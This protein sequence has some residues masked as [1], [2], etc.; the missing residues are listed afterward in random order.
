M[1]EFVI[2]S[3]LVSNNNKNRPG[4]NSAKKCSKLTVLFEQT[5]KLFHSPTDALFINPKKLQNL[6]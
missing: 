2:N 1:S 6:H 3:S 4:L 5:I